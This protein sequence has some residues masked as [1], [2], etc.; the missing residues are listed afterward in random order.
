MEILKGKP[1][2]EYVMECFRCKTI[3][4]CKESEVKFVDDY[5]EPYVEVTCPVCGDRVTKHI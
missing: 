2:K 1:E 3:L 5:R 4:R